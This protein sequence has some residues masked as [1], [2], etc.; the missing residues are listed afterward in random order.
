MWPR[1]SGATVLLPDR[2]SVFP[3]RPSPRAP[4]LTVTGRMRRLSAAPVVPCVPMML[5]G[6]SAHPGAAHPI[7]AQATA[8]LLSRA[9]CLLCRANPKAGVAIS[10]F[11]GVVRSGL[12]LSRAAARAAETPG[13]RRHSAV[14]VKRQL[15]RIE[16]ACQ[17]HPLR[18]PPAACP[19]R[20]GRGRE[21]QHRQGRGRGGRYPAT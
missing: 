16:G 4:V 8:R 19:W 5:L 17:A 21:P 12:G 10:P 13:Q 7:H 18:P 20:R 1:G 15:A 11:S 9:I 6:S 3:A 2:R 14:G